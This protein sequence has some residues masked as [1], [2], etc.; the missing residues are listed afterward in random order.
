MGAKGATGARGAKGL[1]HR[2]DG[3]G[4]AK[5]SATAK[6]VALVRALSKLGYAS[7]SQAYGLIRS[8]RVQVNGRVANDPALL[9]A[10]GLTRIEIGNVE[11]EAAAWRC[12]AL[13][14]PR[15]VVTTRTDP[16]G[17]KTVYDMIAD[18]DARVVPIGRLDLASMGLLLL[19]ND[20]QLAD[21]LTDPAT[22]VVRRYVVTVRGEF[23]DDS[24]RSLTN[25]IVDR[26]EPLKAAAIKILKRSQ[27]ETHLIVELT[28]GKN[29]E[30]RRMLKAAGHE[31]T[32]LKRIAFG[33]IELGDLAPGKWR[34]VSPDEIRAAFPK[35]THSAR[36]RS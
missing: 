18:L 35:A 3:R 34:D 12:I 5:A 4:G 16:E 22:G 23:N 31:V 36:M 19:T 27:R 33:G 8:G 14:K 17:R 21:W 7:R 28:E 15:S 25:G 20:T 10:P 32:R 29:R 6:K 11:L 1:P 9:V 13:N 30:I 2:S 24:V 26:G